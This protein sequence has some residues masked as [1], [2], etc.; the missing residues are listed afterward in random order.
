MASRKKP[1][2]FGETYNTDLKEDKAA[3][4]D[5]DEEV[6]VLR[7]LCCVFVLMRMS[8]CKCV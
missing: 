2:E 7:V 5:D 1:E 6:C 8:E 4:D 3:D